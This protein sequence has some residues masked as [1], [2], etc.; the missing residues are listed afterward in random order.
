MDSQ[1]L[2][3]ALPLPEPVRRLLGELP[4]P[5]SAVRWTPVEQRHITLRFIGD[6]GRDE[7][8]RLVERLRRVVVQSFVLPVQGVGAFPLKGHPRV[9]W[10]GVG[11]G[12]PRLH[13]LRQ[14]VDDTVL[15]A[16]VPMDVS[17][18]HPHVTLGRC[19]EGAD[20]E[21][22]RWLRRHR[23]FAGPTF[24]VDA[25]ELYAS[26]LHA[27]GPVHTLIERFPLAGALAPIPPP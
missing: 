17:T 15:M 18:F 11:S 8:G 27:F 1:R 23:E 16:G 7:T 25:F 6:L 2:F 26:E 5:A 20:A 3:L 24:A 19:R 10:V 12:H 13:Q 14:R 9:L 4:E 22:A 21:V